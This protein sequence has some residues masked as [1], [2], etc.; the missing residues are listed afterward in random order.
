MK[1]VLSIQQFLLWV[2]QVIAE[3]GEHHAADCE[4]PSNV[5]N[6]EKVKLM[7]AIFAVLTQQFVGEQ[8]VLTVHIEGAALT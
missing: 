1:C 4:H 7:R 6:E 3:A 2:M 8:A 5:F